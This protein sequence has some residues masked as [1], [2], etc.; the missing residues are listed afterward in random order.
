MWYTELC[1]G[2]KVLS[3]LSK[4]SFLLRPAV[5]TNQSRVD[6]IIAETPG[7][8]PIRVPFFG[9]PWWCSA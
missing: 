1:K 8:K 5:N 7:T 6:M 9:L 3:L 4:F 2:L